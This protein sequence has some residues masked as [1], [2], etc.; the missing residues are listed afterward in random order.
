[1]TSFN[2]TPLLGDLG[3]DLFFEKNMQKLGR[4]ELIPARI[5]HQSKYTYRAH[6][7]DGVLTAI[8]PGKMRRDGAG[9][10]RPAVGDW[11]AT[12]VEANES[13]AVIHA[14]LPRKSSFSRKVAGTTTQEQVIAANIDVVFVVNG[15]DGGRNFNIRGIERYLT[16]VWAS[17]ASPVIVLNKADLC[18]DA[19]THVEDVR[20]TVGEVPIL[21]ISATEG[22]GIDNLKTYVGKGNTAALLGPSGVGKSSIINALLGTEQLKVGEVRRSDF[23]G[24]HTTAHRELLLLPDGGMVIDTPGMRELQLWADDDAL[25][26]TFPDIQQL[27]V[28]CRFS[29]CQHQNEPGC[30]VQ[31]AIQSGDLDITRFYS[32]QKLQREL[33]Y[34]AARTDDRTRLEEK[35]KWK[36]ISQWSKRIK[37]NR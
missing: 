32:Y 22:L 28:A 5:I 1:M 19:E 16:L 12:E 33:N 23:R 4:Q 26:D 9:V 34:L 11:V 31:T 8:L 3:W 37:K 35:A 17:G 21:V 36:K 18:P 6:G 27:A 24:R 15:L 10:L 13:K 29:D 7:A 2:T 30:A 25:A 20:R 14:V